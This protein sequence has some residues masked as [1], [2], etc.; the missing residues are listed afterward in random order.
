MNARKNWVTFKRKTEVSFVSLSCIVQ[1]LCD[2]CEYQ[3][4]TEATIPFLSFR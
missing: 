2:L 4:I 1:T 3:V